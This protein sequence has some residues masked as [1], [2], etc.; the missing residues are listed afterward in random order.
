MVDTGTGIDVD[1][2]EALSRSLTAIS[3]LREVLVEIIRHENGEDSAELDE[4]QGC[5]QASLRSLDG[6]REE[7]SKNARNMVKRSWKVR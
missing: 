4:I 1:S 5:A 7:L 2:F 6:L 3:D